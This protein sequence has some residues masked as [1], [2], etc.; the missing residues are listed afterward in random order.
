MNDERFRLSRAGVVNVWQ[1]DEQVFDFGGGRLLLRGTNGA[2]KSKTLEMLLPFVIDGDKSRITASGRHH[3]S[4]LWLMLDGYDGPSRTGYL[5]VEFERRTPGGDR[6]TVTCGIGL[7]ASES[8][9]AGTAWY[10]TSPRRVGLDLH[11]TDAAGPLTMQR[12]RAEVEADGHF[13]EPNAGRRYRE[14]VGQLLFG[15]P[16]DQYDDLL[17]LLYWLRQPQV[18]EDIDPK[19]LAEQLVQALPQVDESAIRT[20][21]DTF[22]QLEEFGE[23]IDRQERAAAAIGD[24]LTTYSSYACGVVEARAS[25]VVEAE[26]RVRACTRDVRRGERELAE[27]EALLATRRDERRAADQDRDGAVARIQQ[28]RTSPEARAQASLLRLEEHL[29]TKQSYAA[30]ARARRDAQQRRAESEAGRATADGDRLRAGVAAWG[31]HVRAARDGLGAAQLPGL[32]TRS[33]QIDAPEPDWHATD[34]AA[35]VAASLGAAEEEIG[36]ADEAIGVARAAVTVV[37]QARAVAASAQAEAER[38]EGD[39]VQREADLERRRAALETAVARS[40]EAGEQLHESLAAWAA[41]DDAVDL[42]LPEL[43]A[44]RLAVLGQLVEDA[45]AP[46]RS[47]REERRAEARARLAQAEAERERLRAERAAVAG[48]SDPPPAAPAWH[49]DKREALEGAPL[50]RLVD[51]RDEGFGASAAAG[52]EAALEGSGLL[53]AWV[54][55]DGRLASDRFDTFVDLAPAEPP[56]AAA[57]GPAA[58]GPAASGRAERSLP[59]PALGDVLRADVPPGSAVSAEVVEAILARVRLLDGSAAAVGPGAP[60]WATVAHDGSWR[61]GDL[62]GRTTKPAA[63]YIGATARA[64]ERARRLAVI[65]AA[66][67]GLDAV[68]TEAG[69]RIATEETALGALA[70]WQRARPPHEPLLRAWL[71]EDQGRRLVEEAEAAFSAAQEVAR[72]ARTAAADAHR[73]LV[74]LG[75]VHRLPTTAEGLQARS[76]ALAEL[77]V[78]LTRLAGDRTALLEAAARWD[79]QAQRAR[80]EHERLAQATDEVARHEDEAERAAAELDELRRA[81]GASVDELQRRL[82][83]LEMRRA[84]A[85]R[86]WE[87]LGS[88]I[89]GLVGAAATT[90]ANLAAARSRLDDAKPDLDEARQRLIDLEKAPGVIDSALGRG[91][92]AAGPERAGAHGER[93]PTQEAPALGSAAYGKGLWTPTDPKALLA[94]LPGGARADST[95]VIAATQLLLASA[96]AGHEPRFTEVAGAWVAVGQGEGG[97]LPLVEL[98]GQL[99]AAVAANKELLSQRERQ[100]FEEQVLGYLGDS[101][102]GVRLKAEELVAAMN[103]QLHDVTTSQGIRVRLRWRLRD[104]IPADAKRAVELLGQPIGALLASERVELRESLHRLIDASRAEA[105]EESYAEHLTRALDYRRWFAFAVQYHRPETGEWRDLQRKSALSQGEQKVLCYLP[106]FAAAAAHFTSVAG[107]APHAPRFV[108]LD[109]AF[110]KIDARTHPLLFGLLVDLDLDFVVTSERLWG[111][112]STVPELAIYEA[113]RS[114]GE[115]GIAQY[116]HRWDGQQLTAVGAS[117]G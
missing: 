54:T 57:S 43:T 77:S 98:E 20:A 5:W 86:A 49:R 69:A 90:G 109:D 93:T 83:E 27:T 50:W 105:P 2:G 16:L 62:A 72:S 99:A 36:V 33:G 106:L 114:P 24:F 70:R 79:E 42:T 13:F 21:G 56:I 74:S 80:V 76:A 103:T 66:L 9:R 104:D 81:A 67:T 82:A 41:H 12:L 117:L 29:T 65:D 92:L 10:F 30:E 19:R 6:E 7:R 25:A 64:A 89:E 55:G 38:R 26:A 51:F 78:A 111:T 35:G 46:V 32:L 45:V 4:L 23:Q 58:S 18:G 60:A 75:E 95:S 73:A 100:I 8:A 34:S 101:L 110:P 96:A 85:T 88:E 107:A 102:R 28:L 91:A 108:L 22:D 61:V 84:E 53:D 40:L 15:L 39:S 68:I 44:D 63:Q 3:T 116:E 14:H 17:R 113:L 71:A 115:R 47:G 112:H 11:L 87:E 97:E 59:F 1:Y 37:E 48:E 31:S 94:A 52:L